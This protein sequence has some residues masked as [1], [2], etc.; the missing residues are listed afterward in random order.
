MEEEAEAEADDEENDQEEEE[1]Q[2]LVQDQGQQVLLRL[3]SVIKTGIYT[4]KFDAMNIELQ[5]KY[6][7]IIRFLMLEIKVTIIDKSQ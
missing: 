4:C 3:P 6:Q 5:H 2:D 7:I 1:R